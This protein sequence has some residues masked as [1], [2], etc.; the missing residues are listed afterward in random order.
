MA[1]NALLNGMMPNMM[2]NNPLMMLMSTI[3][4]GGNPQQL[5]KQMAGN[6]PQIQ[7]V[8]NMAQAG[9]ENGLKEMAMNLAK[10]RGTSVEE[11]AKNL[12]IKLP[13]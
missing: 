2:Q 9:N 11:I 8:L 7:E 10:E 6:N 5:L 12:G 13:E 4:N 1:G 3:R